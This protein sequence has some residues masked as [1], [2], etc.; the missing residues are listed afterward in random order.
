MVTAAAPRL[1]LLVPPAEQTTHRA[2]KHAAYMYVTSCVLNPGF[3]ILKLE[4]KIDVFDQAG[5]R[6]RP[7]RSAHARIPP[8]RCGF[9]GWMW[10]DIC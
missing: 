4:K 5:L 7:G 10:R 3:P 6:N 1:R 8:I 2:R 9:R